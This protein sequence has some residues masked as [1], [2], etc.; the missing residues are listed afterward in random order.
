MEKETKLELKSMELSS[1]KSMQ[2]SLSAIRAGDAGL[3]ERRQKMLDRV[4]ESGSFSSF[5]KE[6]IE[7]KDLAYLTAKTG[8]EF[9]LLRGKNT[10]ILFHG[11]P[12]NCFFEGLLEEML[13]S[14]KVEIVGHSHP[15][16]ITPVVSA[17]DRET[18]VRIGQKRSKLIS[19]VSG[20]CIEYGQSMFEN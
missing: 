10:D 1:G 5:S 19:A 20:E 17:D 15:G 4:P 18:L 13:L 14:R 12:V 9:A 3:N 2:T 6:Y 16:E 7:M 8:D 11:T